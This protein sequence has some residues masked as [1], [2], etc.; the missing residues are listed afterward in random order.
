MNMTDNYKSWFLT[1]GLMFIDKDLII[2]LIW[3]NV[4]KKP[5]PASS[6][7]DR[8][9]TNSA[10]RVRFPLPEGPWFETRR[11]FIFSDA[12]SSRNM[13]DGNFRH[14][15]MS[16]NHATSKRKRNQRHLL[17]EKWS[18]SLHCAKGERSPVKSVHILLR[19]STIR[20]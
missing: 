6:E 8:P 20:H 14:T 10:I 13:F 17:N 18:S 4:I 11:G 3:V 16:I 15:D 19:Y 2:K 7:E 1:P 5:G 12:S 9:P